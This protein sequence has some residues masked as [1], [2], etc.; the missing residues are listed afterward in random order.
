MTE[1]FSKERRLLLGAGAALALAPGMALAQIAPR[2][3]RKPLAPPVKVSVGIIAAMFDAV[4]LIAA[5][6]GYFR[7]EGLDV[8][9][10]AF[11][12]SG[13]AAQAL[14]I[15]AIDALASGPNPMIFNS[16]QRN[17]DLTIVASAGQHSPGHGSI[18][19]VMRRDLVESGRYK[20]PADLKGMKIASGL[21]APSSWF[22]SELARRGG[23]SEK[24]FEIVQLGLP[25]VVAGL[26]NKSIDAGCINEPHATQV[27]NRVN[28][29]R[30]MS[31]DQFKPNFPNGYLLFAAT[32]TRKNPEAGRRYMVAYM[33]ALRDYREAFILKQRDGAEL[34]AMLKKYNMALLPETPMVDLPADGQPSFVGVDELVEWHLKMGNMRSRPDLGAL[35]NDSFRRYAL[36]EL[37]G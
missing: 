29:V 7:E 5:E 31:M 3:A 33:R 22:V 27:L 37:G 35:N 34:A 36:Q 11:P 14:A 28:G 21:A 2:A 12:G 24:E 6:K 9:V 25:N 17:I 30:I 10:K 13:E 1:A 18:S 15:G 20:S 26:G 23:V 19:L 4:S 32:L 8:E 16:R